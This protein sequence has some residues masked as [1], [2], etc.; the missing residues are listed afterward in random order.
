MTDPGEL[1]DDTYDF[2]EPDLPDFEDGQAVSAQPL[3]YDLPCRQCDY[4]LRGL[5]EEMACPE[6]G[7]AVVR[8]LLSDHL[9]FSNP[10]WVLNLARGARWL[11]WSVLLGFILGMF[12]GVIEV[13]V[14]IEPLVVSLLTFIPSAISLV[15][16]WLFTSPEPGRDEL[17]AFTIRQAVRWVTVVMVG[18]GLLSIALEDIH[19]VVATTVGGLSGVISLAQ[20]IML[21]VLARRL[22]LRIPNN[23]LAK[24]TRTVMWGVIISMGGAFLSGLVGVLLMSQYPG[25]RMIIFMLPLCAFGIAYL[26]FAIWSLVLLFWYQRAATVA[27]QQAKESWANDIGLRE[28]YRGGEKI[29]RMDS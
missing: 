17:S 27:A 25:D 20:Y 18:L 9:R 6:C 16:V 2:V 29:S 13:V 5:T 28:V 26:V 10:D 21:F 11:I 23:K 15:G 1:A 8:S 24:Q 19:V 22:A 3:A 4:N 14:P 7:T 12:S